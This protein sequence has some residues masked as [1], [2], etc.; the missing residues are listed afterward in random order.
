MNTECFCI[1][2]SLID[3]GVYDIEF[4]I[5]HPLLPVY[6]ATDASCDDGFYNL[7]KIII[8]KTRG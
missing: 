6:F 8:G 4:G 3:A 7:G 1:E 5:I 2:I